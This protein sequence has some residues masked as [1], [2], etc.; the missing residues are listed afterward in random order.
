MGNLG[1]QASGVR[2]GGKTVDVMLL[3][4]RDLSPL[5]REE[6]GD[7]AARNPATYNQNIR[8]GR[9]AMRPRFSTFPDPFWSVTFL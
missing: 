2:T 1:V 6:V 5:P 8:S 7:G 4:K 3:D 9:A